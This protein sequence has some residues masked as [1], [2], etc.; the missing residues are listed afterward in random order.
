MCANSCD[1]Y[2]DVALCYY[3]TKLLEIFRKGGE[4]NLIPC[5]W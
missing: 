2:G 3:D 5:G 1:Q 4:I